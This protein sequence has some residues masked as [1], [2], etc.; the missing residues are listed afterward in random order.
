MTLLLMTV[1]IALNTGD[2]SL[3]YDN[4]LQLQ[5]SKSPKVAKLAKNRPIW[6][7]CNKVHFEV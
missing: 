6:S 4:F 3:D 5:A 7:H 1:L 2:I